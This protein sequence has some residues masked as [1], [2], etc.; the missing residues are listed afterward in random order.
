MGGYEIP[1]SLFKYRTISIEHLQELQDDFEVLDAAGKISHN[2][3]FR[4]YIGNKTHEH[5]E[6]FP[7]A[8]SVIVIAVFTPLLISNFHYKGKKHEVLV[9]HY[10]DDGITEEHLRNTI[11]NQIIR[12]TRY[13]VENANAHVLFKRL[14]VRSGLGR[15]GRNNLC[16]VDG[17]GSFLRLHAYF[18]D[19]VFEE[20]SW[21]EAKLMDSC[22][23]CKI[24]QNNCPTGSISEDNFVIDIEKCI[25][26]YNEIQGDFPEWLDPYS[27]N[28][29][30][31]CMKC[32]LIC[33]A[34]STV[35]S[36][37]QTLDDIS[38]EETKALL[39]GNPDESQISALS[40]KLR[41]FTPENAY[42]Y[43]PVLSR[44]LRA[45]IKD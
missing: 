42:Y 22:A 32:Q 33:S 17:M 31:G 35:V 28:A 9:P 41:M 44:N 37:T 11:Q 45:L 3:V 23:N 15:Y 5:P 12:N 34:N 20:D 8:K 16:Y 18:T 36:Q 29:F 25:P 26:L 43:V 27:H 7:D 6:A 4:E 13:R 1:S 30:M 2:A 40:T 39:E 14:A 10:Y 38:E 19:Y 21:T 24:C